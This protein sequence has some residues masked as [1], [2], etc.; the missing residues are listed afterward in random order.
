MTVVDA[1]RM[2]DGIKATG[3]PM[4]LEALQVLAAEYRALLEKLNE[5]K[6]NRQSR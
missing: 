6:V 5:P 1:L 2:A 3:E 4:L